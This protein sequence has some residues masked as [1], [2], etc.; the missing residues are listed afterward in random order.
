MVMFPCALLQW[1]AAEKKGGG[2]GEVPSRENAG[3]PKVLSLKELAFSGLAEKTKK[4]NKQ[5]KKQN[6]KQNK[7]ERKTKQKKHTIPYYDLFYFILVRIYLLRLS[8]FFHLPANFTKMLP[9]T[10]CLK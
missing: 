2:G 6:K 1:G 4:T 9:I 8:S 7:N 10:I 3:S 5:T